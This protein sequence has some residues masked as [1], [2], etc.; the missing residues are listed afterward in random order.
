MACLLDWVVGRFFALF[1][2]L[3]PEVEC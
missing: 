2:W 1:G 3:F